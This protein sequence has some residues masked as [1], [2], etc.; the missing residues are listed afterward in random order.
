M[1]LSSFALIGFYSSRSYAAHAAFKAIVLNRLGDFALLLVL[2]RL[3]Y[4]VLRLW[5]CGG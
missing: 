4:L 5:I 1:G 3:C 2:N